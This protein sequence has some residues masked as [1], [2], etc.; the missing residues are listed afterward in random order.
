MTIAE[1]AYSIEESS[2]AS[3]ASAGL[4]SLAATGAE[5]AMTIPLYRPTILVGESFASL[6][7]DS[8][9]K[10]DD[11]AIPPTGTVGLYISHASPARSTR[12]TGEFTRIHPAGNFAAIASTK[13]SSP[14]RGA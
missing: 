12:S 5:V 4:R 6:N 3:S 9:V 10:P 7:A 11:A 8:L 1:P 13:L 2:P 14:S